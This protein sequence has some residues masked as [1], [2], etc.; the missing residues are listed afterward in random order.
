MRHGSPSQRNLNMFD[1]T[2]VWTKRPSGTYAEQVEKLKQALSDCD[3]VLIGAGSG[4]STSAGFTY[5]GERF[6]RYFFDFIAKYHI[7]DLYSGG[8]YPFR[9]AEEYW[10]WW[11]RS[12]WINRYM[13]APKP[14]YN[15][16]LSLVKDRDYFVLTTNVDHCFQKAGFDKQRLFYTQG[17]YG[18]F[19]SIQPK[20][21]KTYDNEEFVR[22]MILSQGFAIGEGGALSVPEGAALKMEVPTELVPVCPDDGR[23]M[24]PNLRVDDTFVEDAGWHAASR[25]Y[26]DFIESHDGQNVLFWE[27]GVGGNT[28]V[29]IKYPFWRMTET[30]KNAT[31][32]CLNLGDAEAPGEIIERSI[33]IDRDIGDTLSML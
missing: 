11:S 28:P 30:N 7:P 3:A 22:E 25:R 13:D 14:V 10:A 16:L 12:I 2:N 26:A 31:Y 9:S 1:F 27:L 8:F 6:E 15:T 23:R 19:Q 32:A 4:L 20:V 21:K 24:V 17:D 18:L 29:I 5:S 33:C